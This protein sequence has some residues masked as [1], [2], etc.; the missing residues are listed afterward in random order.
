MHKNKSI[1]ARHHS[2][3]I[4]GPYQPRVNLNKILIKY[5]YTCKPLLL[6]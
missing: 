2:F 5:N 6:P 4:L 3:L 1:V